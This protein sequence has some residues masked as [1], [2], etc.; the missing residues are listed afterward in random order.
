MKLHKIY[1]V[2]K[3]SKI[4]SREKIYFTDPY[5]FSVLG[6]GYLSKIFHSNKKWLSYGYLQKDS[7]EQLDILDIF[8]ILLPLPDWCG[9]IDQSSVAFTVH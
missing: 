7:L 2:K 9:Y 3:W 4:H 6:G 8:F 5:F 1:Y